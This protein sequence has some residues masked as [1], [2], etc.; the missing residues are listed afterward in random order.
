MCGLG[1]WVGEGRREE[2]EVEGE[3][4]RKYK[5]SENVK[6]QHPDPSQEFVPK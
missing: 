1:G 6:V 2:K 5:D 3:K 4:H